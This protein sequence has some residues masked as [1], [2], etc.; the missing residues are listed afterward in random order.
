MIEVKT[1][2]DILREGKDRKHAVLCLI[3]YM[4][5]CGYCQMLKKYIAD[6]GLEKK[7][8]HIKFLMLGGAYL[9]NSPLVNGYP[10]IF[11]LKNFEKVDEIRGY[12][13]DALENALRKYNV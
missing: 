5:W 13:P 12:N 2:K 4:P 3:V 1:K 6:A 10:M 11:M 9:H 7:Y 8:S